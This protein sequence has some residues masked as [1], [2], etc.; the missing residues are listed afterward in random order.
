MSCT[1]A[2]EGSIPAFFWP[3]VS[4]QALSSMTCSAWVYFGR[5]GSFWS[6]SI[7]P[8]MVPASWL[9]QHLTISKSISS[10]NSL[11]VVIGLRSRP[12]IR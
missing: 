4:S 5:Y 3:F 12:G 8:A 10:S 7:V 6:F 2:W 1:E 9:Y 11:V